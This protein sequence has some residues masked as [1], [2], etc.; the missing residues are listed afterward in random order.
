MPSPASTDTGSATAAASAA[1]T[2]QDH[3]A[4]WNV[5]ESPAT[6][7]VD[8]ACDALVAGLDG[9]ALRILAARTRAEAPYEVHDL[10]P[11]ALG[12]LGLTL[13]PHGSAAG[14]E[15]A[16]RAL[17]GRLVAGEL[18]PRDLAFRIHRRFGHELPLAQRL[19]ELDDEYDMVEIGVAAPTELDAE[20]TTEARRLATWPA[21]A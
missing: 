13:P 9:P 21:G 19:A 2:L 8:A 17:A 3:A 20:V 10:L 11:P 12:E 15:A 7:V 18:S 6:A 4:L 1:R 16:V 14:Q 5:G